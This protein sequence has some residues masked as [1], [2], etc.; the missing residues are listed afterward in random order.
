MYRCYLGDGCYATLLMERST[1]R[2]GLIN[3]SE[4]DDLWVS[5]NPDIHQTQKKNFFVLLSL[6]T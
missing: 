5:I 4:D 3:T 6:C 1:Q 2:E